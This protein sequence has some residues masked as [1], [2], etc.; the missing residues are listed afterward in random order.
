LDPAY[1]YSAGIAGDAADMANAGWPWG[2]AILPALARRTSARDRARN[3]FDDL[4]EWEDEAPPPPPGSRGVAPEEATE[5]LAQI[6]GSQA[7]ERSTQREFAAA[8]AGVFAPPLQAHAPIA[9]L[10][11][12]GTGIG[13]T[14]GY[15]APASLWAERNGGSV[16]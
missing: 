2:E 14:L 13:K 16:W 7:E 6:V 4:P 11:E 8:V 15:V 9:L 1:P 12:A 5:R 10:A 3:L